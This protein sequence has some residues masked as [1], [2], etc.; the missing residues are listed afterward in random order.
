M[1]T[2]AN[3]AAGTAPKPARRTG[4]DNAGCLIAESFL[5]RLREAVRNALGTGL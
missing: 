2:A 5:R 3:A 4:A 1:V